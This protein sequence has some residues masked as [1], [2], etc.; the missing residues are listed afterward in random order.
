MLASFAG[1]GTT[2]LAAREDGR[3]YV[4]YEI[5]RAC[6]EHAWQWLEKGG[7]AD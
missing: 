1:S 7:R 6:A 4:G 5:N 2:C 3:N